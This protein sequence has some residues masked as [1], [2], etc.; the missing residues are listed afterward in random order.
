MYASNY[1]IYTHLILALGIVRKPT[2]W[3]FITSKYPGT[4]DIGLPTV[5]AAMDLVCNHV[6]KH[7]GMLL[8]ADVIITQ[9]TATYQPRGYQILD[10]RRSTRHRMLKCNTEYKRNECNV[11]TVTT[12]LKL[13]QGVQLTV[14][15]HSGTRPV[16][17]R[18]RGL[19]C[20][21]RRACSLTRFCPAHTSP[22]Q[23]ESCR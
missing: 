8:P 9:P 15:T 11:A 5:S 4:H 6:C 13:R 12:N 23:R 17:E 19:S 1:H 7:A 2:V 21:V 14:R 22:P 3:V 10:Y 20:T 18:A 16:G